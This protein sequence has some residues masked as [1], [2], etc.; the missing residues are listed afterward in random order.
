MLKKT[1]NVEL[2][3]INLFVA[4]ILIPLN[5]FIHEIEEF[6]KYDISPKFQTSK[7]PFDNSE[8]SNQVLGQINTFNFFFGLDVRFNGRFLYRYD[9]GKSII[10]T[11]E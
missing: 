5:N 11:E 1:E 3:Q 4:L 9:F 2:D 7:S 10:H 8:K 6:R